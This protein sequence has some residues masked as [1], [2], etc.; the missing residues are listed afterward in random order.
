[1]AHATSVDSA[2]RHLRLRVVW[3]SILLALVLSALMLCVENAQA[4]GRPRGSSGSRSSAAAAAR[5]QQMIA[6]LQQQ[7]SAARQVLSTAESQANM[8]SSQVNEA[9][10]KITSLRKTLESAQDEVKEA[11]RVL[12][13]TEEEILEGQG[14]NSQFRK[15]QAALEKA[16]QELH[17]TVVSTLKIPDKPAK[18]GAGGLTELA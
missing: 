14:T 17:E 9:V 3:S 7:L 4:R 16:K 6:A 8:S 10:G 5:K 12:Q 1:M 11:A 18:S 15:D 2:R 13:E